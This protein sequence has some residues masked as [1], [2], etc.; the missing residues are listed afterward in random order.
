VYERVDS[1]EKTKNYRDRQTYSRKRDRQKRNI[2]V[3]RL[4]ISR[5]QV[6]GYTYVMAFLVVVIE[7]EN[8]RPKKE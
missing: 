7:R 4:P 1:L 8:K 6:V 2:I 3:R 5:L